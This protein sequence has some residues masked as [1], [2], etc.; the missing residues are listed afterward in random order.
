MRTRQTVLPLLAVLFPAFYLPVATLAQTIPNGAAIDAEVSKIMNRTHA[1]GVAVA[2]IDHGKVGYVHV[3]VDD[4]PL[5][6]A[7]VPVHRSPQWTES[8]RS[9]LLQT[10]RRFHCLAAARVRD[11]THWPMPLNFVRFHRILRVGCRTAL[12]TFSMV[13]AGDNTLRL[14]QSIGI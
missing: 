11:L 10:R 13:D 6:G 4:Q 2:V 8:D 5:E 7:A 1:K 9:P 14:A 12:Q 3:R